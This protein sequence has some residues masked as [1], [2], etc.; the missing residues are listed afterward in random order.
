M[1]KELQQRLAERA[2]RSLKARAEGYDHKPLDPIAMK[3][4]MDDHGFSG[5]KAR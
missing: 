2:V 4:F 1:D 5:E 3:K